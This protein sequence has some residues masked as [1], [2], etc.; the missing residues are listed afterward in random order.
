MDKLSIKVL[1]HIAREQDNVSKKS[2]IDRFGKLASKSLL[3]LESEGL[4]KSGRV[5]VGIG[6][7]MKPVFSS[8][9]IFSITSKGLSHLEEK[10][11]K[12]FDRWLTRVIAIWGAIT[13]TGAIVLEILLHSQLLFP[14]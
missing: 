10:P 5:P 1:K 8:N 11:G 9:G 12:D 7:E 13:G 14:T 3:F 6:A 2:V 4:I